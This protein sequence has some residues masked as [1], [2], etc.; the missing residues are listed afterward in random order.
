M[1][2]ATVRISDGELKYV[3]TICR[4]VRAIYREL[5]LL[6]PDM[7]DNSEMKKKMETMLQSVMKI[8][9]S[10]MTSLIFSVNQCRIFSFFLW[11]T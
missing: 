7:D 4:F 10:N 6:V 5:I 3:E 1:R 9:T 2:V 11:S 8:E